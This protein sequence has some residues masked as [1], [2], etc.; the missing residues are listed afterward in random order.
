MECRHGDVQLENGVPSV[1]NIDRWEPL[2]S[3]DA[4]YTNTDDIICQKLGFKHGYPTRINEDPILHLG[5]GEIHIGTCRTSGEFPYNCNKKG[6]TTCIGDAPAY[7]IS[8][9]GFSRL[10]KSSCSKKF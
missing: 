3:Q 8:C 9:E 7:E 4:W 6:I 2:C 10:T 1:Y 5:K